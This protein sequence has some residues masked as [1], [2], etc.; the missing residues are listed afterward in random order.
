MSDCIDPYDWP[1]GADFDVLVVDDEPVVRDAVARM[2]ASEALRAVC[3]DRGERALT[4]RALDACRLLV[5]DLMMPGMSGLDLI[6][7]VR[8]RRPG[9]P[10]L[11]ITGYATPEVAAQVAE[12]GATEFL[13]KPFDPEE[14]LVKVR[15]ILA[16]A[17]P[18]DAGKEV[19]S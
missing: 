11:A 19:G 5:C 6:R 13:A 7:A 16:R 4:H 12:S 1:E 15:H 18:D 9:L 8:A 2:L 17:A 10:V 3:V 14:L